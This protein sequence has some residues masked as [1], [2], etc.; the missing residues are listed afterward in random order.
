LTSF[1]NIKFNTGVRRALT[2]GVIGLGRTVPNSGTYR[3]FTGTRFVK[4]VVISCALN[5]TIISK[6]NYNF[7][8]V[9]IRFME[10]MVFL[11]PTNRISDGTR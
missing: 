4:L 1:I 9:S 11:L 6:L 7:I 2:A 3:F 5:V 8:K 10:F